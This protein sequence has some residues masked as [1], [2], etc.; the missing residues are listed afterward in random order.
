MDFLIYLLHL[1]KVYISRRNNK[2]YNRNSKST[3]FL[4]LEKYICI[5]SKSKS[6]N[7]TN[8]LMIE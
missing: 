3:C 2:I 5:Y 7:S 4:S 8:K 1:L 6:N